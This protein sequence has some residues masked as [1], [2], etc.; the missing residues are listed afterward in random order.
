L[1]VEEPIEMKP[2]ESRGATYRHYTQ[3]IADIIG[4]YVREY[5]GQWFWAHKRWGRPKGK[6]G[7]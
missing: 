4:K 7:Y 5:P 3:A 1:F 2:L 6:V